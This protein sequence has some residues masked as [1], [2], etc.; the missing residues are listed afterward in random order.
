MK[1]A[2]KERKILKNK[3][4]ITYIESNK[5]ENLYYWKILHL[6]N[7][8]YFNFCKIISVPNKLDT[9][10]FIIT[11]LVSPLSICKHKLESSEKWTLKICF[12]FF[13]WII[14]LRLELDEIMMKC[15][16]SLIIMKKCSRQK[17]KLKDVE[18]LKFLTK[19]Q[20]ELESWRNSVKII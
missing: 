9:L 3:Y 19:R 18:N 13:V 8:R 14:T 17:K 20:K 1:N 12:L 15:S 6:I 11:F 10:L 2:K 5:H 4:Q 16:V 7:L